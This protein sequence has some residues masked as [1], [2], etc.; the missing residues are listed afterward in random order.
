MKGPAF[1][2]GGGSPPW[3]PAQTTK[4]QPRGLCHFFQASLE[5]R[6]QRFAQRSLGFADKRLSGVPNSGLGGLPLPRHLLSKSWPTPKAQ[7]FLSQT[8]FSP[9]TLSAQTEIALR[10]PDPMPTPAVLELGGRADPVPALA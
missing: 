3:R 5:V 4:R 1:H 10:S 9:R 7:L 2:G 6:G 8:A